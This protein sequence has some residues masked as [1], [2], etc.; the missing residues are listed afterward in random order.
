MRRGGNRPDDGASGDPLAEL[1]RLIGQADPF[2]DY[3]RRDGRNTAPREPQAG[4][5]WR[6]QAASMPPY[7]APEEAPRAPSRSEPRFPET[8]GGRDPYRTAEESR[9]PRL[10]PRH[11]PGYEE[12]PSQYR[13]EPQYEDDGYSDPRQDGRAYQDGRS[14][15]DQRAYQDERAYDS[16]DQRSQPAYFDDGAPMGA[17]DDEDYD[18]PPRSRRRGGLLTAV[19]LIGCAMIGTAGAYGYRT[20]YSSPSSNRVP[21]VIS[22]DTTPTKVVSA[23]EGPTGKSIK[24]RV[25]DTTER[26]IPREEEPVELRTP[27]RGSQQSGFPS[28]S[29]PG[30]LSSGST[31]FAPPSGNA[32][33]SESRRVRTLTIRPDGESPSRESSSRE[34]S[35]E[36]SSREPS[37]RTASNNPPPSAAPARP[38]PVPKNP[39]SRNTAPIALDPQEPVAPPAPR[40]RTA[41]VAPP[42]TTQGLQPP[43]PR[44]PAASEGAASGYSVQLSS[45]RSEA[46]AQAS[47]RSLQSKY[48]DQLSDRSVMI[49]R[50]DLGAKGVYYRAMVGPFASSDEATQLCSELKAAGGQCLIQRN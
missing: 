39:P 13:R 33:S 1:A 30:G 17:D 48:P 23:A 20:Y 3:G 36:L 11:D 16:H 37:S 47:Y 9:D 41:V 14:Y 18:D 15:Q 5:D 29:A 4:T 43:A 40:E 34:Q 22:A 12:R 42:A 7:E 45:Q 44:A 27:S 46:E 25:G 28:S 6:R 10:D 19:T 38:T 26:V 24:D 32:N 49:R 31:A 2:S 21:P 35:R 50:V 8:F